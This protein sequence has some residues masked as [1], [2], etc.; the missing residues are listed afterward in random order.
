ML[1]DYIY[2]KINAMNL[3]ELNNW[4]MDLV[5]N[6]QEDHLKTQVLDEVESALECI[7]QGYPEWAACSNAG[8]HIAEILEN[9]P[10]LQKNK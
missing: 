3:S 4:A 10:P 9:Y 5:K 7:Q 8:R 2:R 6:C 1:L